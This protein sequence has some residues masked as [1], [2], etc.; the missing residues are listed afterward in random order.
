MTTQ[1]S[2]SDMTPTGQRKYSPQRYLYAWLIHL[3]TASA[4]IL[5]VFT[6]YAIYQGNYL[7]AFWLMGGTIFID[8]IDGTLA[9]SCGVKNVVPRIDGALL[10]NIMDYFNYVITPAFLLLVSNLLPAD[11]QA[12]GVSLMV[13]ASAYQFT[14]ADAKTEDNFFKGFP[15]YWNLVVFYLFVADLHPWLNFVIIALLA[16]LVFIPIKYVY[17]T[18]LDHVSYNKRLKVTFILATI[19][20]A[21]ATVHLLA[22][23]PESSTFSVLYSWFFVLLYISVS[24]YRTFKPLPTTA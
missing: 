7:L 22:I 11:W 9:R 21:L 23:Y 1:Q 24:L 20:Y 14:Q 8:S 2:L 5:G 16:V 17:L 13:L 3:F 10:D 18:R 12:I 6:L 19:I 15:S 4:A